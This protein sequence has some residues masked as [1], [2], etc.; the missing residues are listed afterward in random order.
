MSVL[1]V[2]FA[3]PFSRFTARLFGLWPYSLTMLAL[4]LALALPFW[5]SGLTKWDG[6]FTLSFGAQALFADEY[7]LH[8]FGAQYPFPYPEY[9]ALAS[10]IGEVTLPVLLVLGLFTRFAAAGILAMT[11]II[12]ITYPDG[13]QNFHLPWAAMALA[14]LSFGGGRIALDWWLGLDREPRR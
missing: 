10:A 13:W 1:A 12:Q 4:R 2:P 9:M 8:W 7:K 14:I 11:A 3:R 5:K 6:W